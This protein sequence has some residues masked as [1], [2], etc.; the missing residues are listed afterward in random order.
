MLKECWKLPSGEIITTP[1][2]FAREIGVSRGI[3]YFW[4][5]KGLPIVKSE[6]GKIAVLYREAIEWL[7]EQKKSSMIR[8]TILKEECEGLEEELS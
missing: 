8:K 1:T 7:W 6:K 5:K 2:R 3:I 4:I